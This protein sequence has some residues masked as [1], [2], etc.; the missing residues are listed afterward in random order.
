MDDTL[1][2]I[3]PD[4]SGTLLEI[5]TIER[6]DGSELAIHAMPMRRKYLRLLSGD[7]Q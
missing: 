3:G 2:H 5:L 6:D 4:P 7:A 1:L